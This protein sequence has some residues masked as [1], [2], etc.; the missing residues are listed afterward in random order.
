MSC[1]TTVKAK[2]KTACHENEFPLFTWAAITLESHRLPAH[3]QPVQP[4]VLGYL[5]THLWTVTA[6]LSVFTLRIT[7]K[8]LPNCYSLA[9][10][11]ALKMMNS[12]QILLMEILLQIC[13]I[14]SALRWTFLACGICLEDSMVII[15]E[16][17]PALY[18]ELIQYPFGWAPY[19]LI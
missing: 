2:V 4:Q 14:H 10:K 13:N 7:I 3:S 6:L 15:R 5:S 8:F 12:E 19:I 16:H 9:V 18:Y 11:L 1:I 17:S